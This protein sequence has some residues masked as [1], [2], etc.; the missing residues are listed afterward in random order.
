M[1]PRPIAETIGPPRPSFRCFILVEIRLSVLSRPRN[2]QA[3]ALRSFSIPQCADD[4]IQASTHAAFVAENPLR[5]AAHRLYRRALGDRDD[6]DARESDESVRCVTGIRS[7]WPNRSIERRDTRFWLPV[8]GE[9]SR[10]FAF[11][12]PDVFRFFLRL[13][14]LACAIFQQRGQDKSFPPYARRTAWLDSEGWRHPWRRQ[15]NP[16]SLC[17]DNERCRDALSRRF[18]TASGSGLAMR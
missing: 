11:D 13:H 8:H 18:P 9:Y 16:S 14:R 17:R 15:D 2:R 10:S 4:E 3:T 6:E 1:Q 5:G 7:R 12:G